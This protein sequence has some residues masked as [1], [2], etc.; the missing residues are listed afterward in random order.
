MSAVVKIAKTE[1]IQ[2]EEDTCWSDGNLAVDPWEAELESNL[3]NTI[4]VVCMWEFLQVQAGQG[5]ALCKSASHKYSKITMPS[6]CDFFLR[7]QS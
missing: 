7:F 2:N 6:P 4:L 3:N 5:G 1:Y